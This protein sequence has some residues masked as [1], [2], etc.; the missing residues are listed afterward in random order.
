MAENYNLRG[1]DNDVQV[2]L[3]ASASVGPNHAKPRSE[4]LISVERI[5]PKAAFNS[6][7][8]PS[9]RMAPSGAPSND[10][11]GNP[12]IRSSLHCYPFCLLVVL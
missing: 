10:H 4:E 8:G 3:Q 6:W 11:H 9:F 12:C 1:V 7:L 5:G 2:M